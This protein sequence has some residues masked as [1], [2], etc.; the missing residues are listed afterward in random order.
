MGIR[1]SQPQ[2]AVRSRRGPSAP[3][4]PMKWQ[5]T[6][7]GRETRCFLQTRS[8]RPPP[9]HTRPPRQPGSCRLNTARTDPGITLSSSPASAPGIWRM[10]TSLAGSGAPRTSAAPRARRPPDPQNRRGLGGTGFRRGA[11]WEGGRRRRLDLRLGLPL[12]HP[13]PNDQESTLSSNGTSVKVQ[14]TNTLG[15]AD[16]KYRC[17]VHLLV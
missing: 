1:A 10:T 4:R 7:A 14:S 8:S 11:A 2:Y 9:E 6:P 3:N 13:T 5:S 16:L 12:G 17:P 15:P